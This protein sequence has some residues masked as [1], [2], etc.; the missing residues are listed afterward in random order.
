VI[1]PA[2]AVAIHWLI[3]RLAS[4][5]WID[6]KEANDGESEQLVSYQHSSRSRNPRSDW[7]AQTYHR[8]E[9]QPAR[10]GAVVLGQHAG[11][12]GVELQRFVD[13]D[14]VGE[15]ERG[16]AG[17]GAVGEHAERGMATGQVWI[18]QSNYPPTKM[19]KVGIYTRTCRI[20]DKYRVPVGFV[21]PHIKIASK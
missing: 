13:P 9:G 12:V 2:V 20:L 16:P 11:V 18:G 6:V 5:G 15:P 8:I 4:S 14:A 7:R 10:L 19:L 17:T 21:I 1:R 3:L